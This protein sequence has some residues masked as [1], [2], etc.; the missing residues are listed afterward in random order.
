M[1]NERFSDAESFSFF[2]LVNPKLF[3]QWKEGVPND[4]MQQLIDKYGPL[5]DITKL[6]SQL[7]FIYQDQDF[8]KE[9]STELLE[10]IYHLNM[11]HCIPEVVRLLK[12][13]GVMAV[14]SASAERSFSCLKRVKTY[15]RN[16]M[17]DERLG[18][19]CRI[20]IHKD[21][22]KEKEDKKD[23]HD[24]ILDKFIKKPRR[25]NFTYK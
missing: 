13:N 12:L 23:L 7:L 22:L 1:L 21:I 19:L 5:F 8:V 2:D 16:A 20:S 25:L 15:L 14:S 3:I 24:A 10:Y 4:K 17:G 11:Q 6:K 18:S 9:N